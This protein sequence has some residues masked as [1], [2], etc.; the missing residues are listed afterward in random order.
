MSKCKNDKKNKVDMYQ[1]KK[2]RKKCPHMTTI[3]DHT[4]LVP[5]SGA[6]IL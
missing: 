6:S 1:V 5:R 4:W 2:E 3:L